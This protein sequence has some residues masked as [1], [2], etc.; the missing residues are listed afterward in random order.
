[1]QIKESIWQVLHATFFLA[2]MSI[3]Y[4]SKCQK[5]D[6][7]EFEFE[8]IRTPKNPL[9]EAYRYYF[10]KV[11]QD[12]EIEVNTQ[13]QLDEKD[14]DEAMKAYEQKYRLAQMRRDSIDLAYEAESLEAHEKYERELKAYRDKPNFDKFVENKI[15]QDSERPV[16]QL[17]NRPYVRFPIK[18]QKNSE[19]YQKIFSA[20]VLETTY[21]KLDGYSKSQSNSVK[22]EVTMYGYEYL[23]PVLRSATKNVFNT[24][25]GTT[26]PVTYY[27]YEVSYRHP[28][29]LKVSLPN[30]KVVEDRTF[31]ELTRYKVF[32]TSKKKGSV[33]HID[34]VGLK[35]SFQDRVVEE[36][37]L[38]IKSYINDEY[39]YSREKRST[40]IYRVDSRKEDY[41]AM[42]KA[43]EYA[44]NGYSNLIYDQEKSKSN[45]LEA[46]SIWQREVAQC[47]PN[48]RRARVN[49][50]V[51]IS[52]HFNLFEALLWLEEYDQAEEHLSKIIGIRPSKKEEEKVSTS[53]VFLKQQKAR[54]YN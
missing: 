40:I 49:S 29:N 4:S 26:A 2:L 53:R 46:V 5:I 16:L 13:R 6:E 47:D 14:F 15:L 25:T 17:P 38:F 42:Q 48:D 45:L 33:P 32:K 10:S 24:S 21:L 35:L 7:Q 43:Y 41:A 18:P 39:G 20:E 1:M 3:S 51:G 11:I 27:W 28:M 50:K 19:Y 31:E 12:Y 44:V 37:M 23:D 9:P 30:G 36:N 22:L 54:L 52:L 8:Y 34:Q